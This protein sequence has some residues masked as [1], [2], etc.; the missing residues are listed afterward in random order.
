MEPG[1]SSGLERVS[2]VLGAEDRGS[3]SREGWRRDR[4]AV[5]A[6]VPLL[7]TFCLSLQ[8]LFAFIYNHL[9]LLIVKIKKNIFFL[10][11]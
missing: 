7:Q 6:V 10:S 9:T 2:T 3:G 5:S 4:Q 1:G 8:L 11:C